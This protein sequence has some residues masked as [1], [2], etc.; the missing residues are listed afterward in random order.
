M[1]AGVGDRLLPAAG[2]ILTAGSL[3]GPSPSAGAAA[4]SSGHT[5][6]PS[7]QHRLCRNEGCPGVWTGGLCPLLGPLGLPRP[8]AQTGPHLRLLELVCHPAPDALLKVGTSCHPP[9]LL[10][11]SQY[12][13]GTE[14]FAG[15]TGLLR[16]VPGSPGGPGIIISDNQ[17]E[18]GK[19][20]SLSF[21]GGLRW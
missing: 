6:V 11:C 9:R 17:S 16:C 19:H 8:P 13:T 2:P 3:G 1:A 10:S 21:P 4:L 18:F 5:C 14:T 20:P 15:R 7:P 12:Q